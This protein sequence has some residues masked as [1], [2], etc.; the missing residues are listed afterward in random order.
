MK[1][2]V[3]YLLILL[4]C[5]VTAFIAYNSFS[6]GEKKR[7]TI[8][9]A[10]RALAML[11]IEKV[12][13][14]HNACMARNE[15]HLKEVETIWVS[16]NGPNAKTVKWTNPTGIYEGWETFYDF[17]VTQNIA[18]NQS[19]LEAINK[20]YPEIEVK[21]ENYGVGS[22]SGGNSPTNPIIE[23]AGDGKTAKATWNSNG[24]NMSTSVRNGKLEVHGTWYW[25]NYFVDFAKEDGAWKIWHMNITYDINAPI[26]AEYGMNYTQYKAP[27]MSGVSGGKYKPNPNPYEQWSPL[28]MPQRKTQPK[29]PEP[30]YT[31]SET[32]SY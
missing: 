19:T 28:R 4:A 15:T 18:G 16:P 10:E 7:L 27:D 23:I 3:R 24:P 29:L 13:R 22:W 8:S 2:K 5:L 17:Y 20:L 11:E 6:A 26:D 32:F 25:R 31:F 21:P 12:M 1:I 30:Y 9:D 14:K